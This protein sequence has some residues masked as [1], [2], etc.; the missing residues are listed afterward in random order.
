M[1]NKDKNAVVLIGL[2]LLFLGLHFAFLRNLWGR[3]KARPDIPLVDAIFTNAATVRQSTAQ[4]KAVGGDTSGVECYTCHERSKTPQLHYD[5]NHNLKLPKEHEDLA[6]NHGR[7]K[8]NDACFNCHNQTNL[9]ALLTRDG[10]TLKIEQSTLLCASCHGPTYRDW[11]IGVH[12]RVS[13]FWDHSLGSA[14]RQDCV[15]CHDPHNPAFPSRHPAPGPHPLHPT[16]ASH[17]AH[18]PPT[19]ESG[20]APVEKKEH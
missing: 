4:L 1:K 10:S 7:N 16:V 18:S 3:P 13:G 8:R 2:A 11:E 20:S 12:G 15:S 17:T 5:T 9:E 6:I 14:T 19:A